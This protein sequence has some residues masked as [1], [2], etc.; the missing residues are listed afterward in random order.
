M[1][2]KE[3]SDDLSGILPQYCRYKCYGHLLEIY[4]IDTNKRVI[5]D[6]CFLKT[7]EWRFIIRSEARG[8]IGAIVPPKT[9]ES[10]FIHHEFVQF[11]K[12]HSRYKTFCHAL[13]YHRSVVKC[14]SSLLLQ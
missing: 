1:F 9:Y 6:N 10:Y 3:Q 11:R 13:L 14:T 2:K 8:A 4:L 5:I 7:S 12:Q